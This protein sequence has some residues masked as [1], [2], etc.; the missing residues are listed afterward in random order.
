MNHRRVLRP[1]SIRRL[2]KPFGWIPLRLV[3]SGLLAR[4]HPDEKLLYLFLSTVADKYGVSFYGDR[5]LERELG[6]DSA[7]IAEARHGLMRRQLIVVSGLTVQL[8]PLPA[9][10]IQP[11]PLRPTPTRSS[12]QLQ[13]IGKILDRLL[14]GR[15]PNPRQSG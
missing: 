3:T 7:R 11:P 6:I 9:L 4:L 2:E 8:L 14:P 1:D 5:R 10:P 12:R 15:G 13:P